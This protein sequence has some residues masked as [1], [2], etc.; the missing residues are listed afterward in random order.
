[1]RLDYNANGY[2]GCAKCRCWLRRVAQRTHVVLVWGGKSGGRLCRHSRQG[3]RRIT[4]DE[5]TRKGCSFAEITGWRGRDT[6][7]VN[8]KE[9]P[10][11]KPCLAAFPSRGITIDSS[12][13]RQLVREGKKITAEK[14]IQTEFARRRN[15]IR[16]LFVT[17][18][19]TYCSF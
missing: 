4:R 14:P 19:A 5:G 6:N 11:R 13:N 12:Y 9:S 2:V 10:G 17:A 8:R 16:E 3:F 7:E 1:M 18:N 15:G